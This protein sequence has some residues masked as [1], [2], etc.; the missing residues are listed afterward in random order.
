MLREPGSPDPVDWSAYFPQTLDPSYETGGS[1]LLGEPEQPRAVDPGDH[2]GIS[3]ARDIFLASPRFRIND[4][5]G[6][7]GRWERAPFAK[8]QLGANEARSL[9]A[10]TGPQLAFEKFRLSRL[11]SGQ[12]AVGH[13]LVGLADHRPYRP[14]QARIG[15]AGGEEPSD[16]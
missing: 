1:I 7:L 16:D 13:G 15:G 5:E 3:S 9:D 4:P 11:E 10:R 14:D 12:M 2:A 8:G 6:H